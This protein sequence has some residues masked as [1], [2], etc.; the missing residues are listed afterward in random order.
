MKYIYVLQDPVNKKVRYVGATTNPKQ[1]FRQHL[2]DAEKDKKTAKTKKQ[3]WILELKK[4][5]MLPEIKIIKKHDDLAQARKIEEETVIEYIDTIYN[6]HMPGKGSLSV[7]HYK[8]TGKL[9]D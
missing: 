5:G 2:K 4:Q 7:K 9:K 6:L 8:K 1:R 3:L